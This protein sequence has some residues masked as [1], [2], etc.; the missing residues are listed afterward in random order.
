MNCGPRHRFI[1]RNDRGEMF[2][3][4]NSMGHGTDGLQTRGH[5]LAWFGLN[6]S[7][8]LYK[9]MNGRL[10]RQGQGVPVICN[11]ILCSG[12]FDQAQATRLADKD[13]GEAAIRAAIKEYRATKERVYA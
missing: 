13:E 1:I 2:V 11:R 3:S 12:T 8:R 4:H 7:P 5:I 6:W 10:R 9:Q